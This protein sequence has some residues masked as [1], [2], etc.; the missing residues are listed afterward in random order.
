MT[1]R[2][3]RVD[4]RVRVQV[5]GPSDPLAVKLRERF[6]HVNPSY[7]RWKT[8]HI[9]PKPERELCT[10]TTEG[11]GR[12]LTVPRGGFEVVLDELTAHELPYAVDD[13][14]VFPVA[15]VLD[16]PRPLWE[17]QK[18]LVG[19]FLGD[20]HSLFAEHYSCL[21]RSPQGSG[22]TQ[23]ILALAAGLGTNTLV[24]VPTSNLL[25]QWCVRVE[26]EL[27]IKPGV[28]QGQ[29]RDIRQITIGMQQTLA[30]CASEYADQ[31]GLVA[32]DEVQLAAAPT[33]Q[34]TVDVFRSRYRLGVSGDERRSDGKECLTYDMFG[35]VAHEV[36]RAD[37]EATG[38]IVDVEVLIVPTDF[39]APWWNELGAEDP[40][41]ERQRVRAA[42][43]KIEERT[44]LIE[45]ITTNEER[46]KLAVWCAQLALED[47]EQV[48]LLTDRREHCH[49]L[50]GMFA[51][52]GVRSGLFIGGA[53]YKNQFAI[54]LA[55]LNAG[56][57]RAA[58]GTYQAVGVGFEA[59]RRLAVGV[60]ASPCVS[61]DKSKLQFNQYRGRFARSAPGKTSGV[62]YY[63]WD[64]HVFG[65]NPVRLLTRWN[66]SVKLLEGDG[67]WIDA[68]HYLRNHA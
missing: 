27:G 12:W 68:R 45:E 4:N 28:I 8:L 62:L 23:S 66:K 42:Q 1:P 40:S 50:D 59:H 63:L 34:F 44:R 60:L 30:K 37:I 13:Q 20:R 2:I 15:P 48:V 49:T 58:V 32:I 64:R 46:N 55:D 41:N 5:T 29:R 22:K 39:R 18:P 17:H 51:R 65:W 61:N 56:R 3:V 14:T 31:F 10:W 25:E 36:K 52:H 54:T 7:K 26:R 53:D 9:G 11:R 24:I 43:M 16:L 6:T 67:S 19:T 47:G 35:Q 21:W 57:I 33:V 38:E